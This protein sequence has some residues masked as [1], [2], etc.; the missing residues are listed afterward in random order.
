V[1]PANNCSKPG[2]LCLGVH[3]LARNAFPISGLITLGM[4][5]S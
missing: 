4:T 2:S 5:W 3:V 1:L